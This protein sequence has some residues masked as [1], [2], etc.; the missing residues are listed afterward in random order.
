MR[1]EGLMPADSPLITTIIPTYRRPVFLKRA[2]KSV[3]RQTYPHFQVCIYDNASGD[4]TADVVAELAKQD[5]RVKYHCHQENIGSLA[6]FD[7]GMTRVVTPFFSLL[8]DDDVLLPGFFETALNGFEK[9]PDAIFSAGSTIAMTPQGKVFAAPL[10]LWPREGYYS[11]PDNVLEMLEGQHPTWTAILFRR[12]VIEKVGL[13]DHDVGSPSDLDYELRAAARFPFVISKSPCAIWLVYPS[14]YSTVGGFD[15]QW[16]GW[17][18]LINKLASDTSI[19][20]STRMRAV[21]KLSARAKRILFR[22]GILSIEKKNYSDAHK[23]A[24][25]LQKHFKLRLKP[26]ILLLSTKLSAGCAYLHKLF[27]YLLEVILRYLA[28]KKSH[29]QDKYGTLSQWL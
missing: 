26:F 6:N 18:K 25:V 13:L 11:P 9:F 17:L 8:S 4:E 15:S 29:L 24:D 16:P 28:W 5:S 21:E 14:S 1:T 7:Y 23:A 22:I 19:P 3:L 2:V 20:E 10:D 27:V 12:E